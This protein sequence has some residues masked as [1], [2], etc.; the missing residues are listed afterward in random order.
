MEDLLFERLDRMNA[1]VEP[2][3]VLQDLYFID[4]IMR[5]LV[6]PTESDYRIPYLAEALESRGFFTSTDAGWEA[7][8]LYDD[9][10]GLCDVQ[11]YASLERVLERFRAYRRS[12]DATPVREL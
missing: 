3:V 6:G 11:S 10:C 7:I 4:R 9:L 8:E 12:R 1:D 5:P 2:E